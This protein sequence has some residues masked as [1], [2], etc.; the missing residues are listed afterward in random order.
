MIEVGELKFGDK[1]VNIKDKLLGTVV[2]VEYNRTID[3]EWEEIEVHYDNTDLATIFYTPDYEYFEKEETYMTKIKEKK[4][5]LKVNDKLFAKGQDKYRVIINDPAVIL[6]V[7]EWN[8]FFGKRQERKYVSK[9]HNEEFDPEKGL[10]MCLAKANGISHLDLKRMLK[11]ATTQKKSEIKTI[12]IE[13][14]LKQQDNKKSNVEVTVNAP[15]NGK[16]YKRTKSP[17]G[18]HKGKSFIFEIGDAVVVRDCLTY[19][20]QARETAKP[21]LNK[22]LM[23]ID[24]MRDNARQYYVVEYNGENYLFAG[25]ELEPVYED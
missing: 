15:T 14:G 8:P 16:C 20:Y 25:C 10:L 23:V 17:I 5:M 13:T 3:N 11:K 2:N 21:M 6:F 22:Q 19:F 18:R 1:V 9:A 7:E 4:E 12:V 24:K